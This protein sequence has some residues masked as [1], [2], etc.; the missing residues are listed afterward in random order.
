MKTFFHVL[1]L[2]FERNR[3]REERD[4]L[5][6]RAF[7]CFE[8]LVLFLLTLPFDFKTTHFGF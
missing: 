6:L 7:W 4:I 3:L 5:P 1:L 2:A 8:S